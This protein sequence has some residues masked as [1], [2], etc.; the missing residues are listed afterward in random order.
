M[1]KSLHRLSF[2]L[3][4]LGVFSSCANI[5]N[6]F[7]YDKRGNFLRNYQRVT[8]KDYND[9]LKGLGHDYISSRDVKLIKLRK[10]E[11]RYIEK[12]YKKILDNNELILRDKNL[13]QFYVVRSKIPFYFSLPGGQYFFSLALFKKY[14]KTEGTFV[15]AF[16]F[17]MFRSIRGLYEKH[18][19]VPTGSVS[20]EKLLSITRIDYSLRVEIGKW[21]YTAMKRAGLNAFVYLNWLQLQ[22]RNA[23]DFTLQQGDTYSSS[24]E[25]YMFKNY[26]INEG[27]KSKEI[28]DKEVNSSKDFYLLIN[29][30]SKEKV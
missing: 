19:L 22:N 1:S 27:L 24:R 4:L 15:A 18:Y 3:I 25:E 11:Q 12:I 26:V 7:S 13:P 20:T 23:L 9:H 17:E 28:Y 2:V 30:L 6:F 29:R 5:R 21:T 8:Q 16:T 14:F 10:S